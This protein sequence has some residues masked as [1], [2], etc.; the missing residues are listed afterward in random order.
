[1]KAYGLKVYG[2]PENVLQLV[3]LPI[4]D[5]KTNEVLVRVKAAAVNDFD[6]CVCTGQPL[7]YR[8]FFGLFKP[9]KALY[10]PGMEVA[11]VV[12]E[13]GAEVTKFKKGDSVFGDISDHGFGSFA[14]CV[15]LNEA[16]LTLMP[17]A[18]SFEDAAS[19]PHASLLALQG[20]E[21]AGAL[22]SDQQILINGGGGG[23]GAFALQLAKNVGAEVTGVDTEPKLKS[24]V[25]QGFDHVIDYKKQ[26]FT[27]SGKQYDLIL[28]CRTSFGPLSYLRALKP[29]GQYVTVGGRSGKL[30]SILFFKFFIHLFTDKRLRILGLKTNEGLDRIAELYEAGKLKCLI[31]G[32]FPFDKLPL[33]IKRFGQAKHHGKVVVS[34]DLP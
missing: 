18:M 12:E 30:L 22:N 1:M 7:A 24:M 4:P 9:R 6:W 14:E 31:D 17:N 27:R 3:D 32:P 20:L 34:V 8:L 23:V 21:L 13:V 33:A 28:D 15:S 5:L 29:S 10:T 19:I 25:D 11:G 16:A 2:D 26:D